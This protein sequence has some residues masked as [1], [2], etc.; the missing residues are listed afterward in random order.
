ML[1][2]FT[3]QYS[4]KISTVELQRGV[5]VQQLVIK[6]LVMNKRTRLI[7]WKGMVRLKRNRNQRII[8][9]PLK[10]FLETDEGRKEVPTQLP[11][12]KYYLIHICILCISFP[13]S[14][15]TGYCMSRSFAHVQFVFCYFYQFA[16]LC[17]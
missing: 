3:Q 12:S 10:G 8:A 17:K 1:H 9:R 16:F 13:S 15:I 2:S 7:L 5:R 11:L 6:K 4:Y 14:T